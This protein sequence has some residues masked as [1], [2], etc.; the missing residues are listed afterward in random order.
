MDKLR[1]GV[2]STAKI[3][4]KKVMP[5]IVKTANGELTAVASRSLEAANEVADAFHIPHRYGSYLELLESDEIDAVYIPLPND[6]HLEWTLAAAEAGKHVL[7]EKPLALTSVDAQAMVDGCA[8]AGVTFM[9]AFMYRLH[10]SWIKVRELVATGEIGELAA[11]VAGFSF[12]MDDPANIRNRPEHGGGALM[13]I[14]CY[15]IN[16]ARMLFGTEPVAVSASMRRHP[17]FGTDTLTSAV[18]EFPSGQATFTV[19]T[20][21]EPAQFVHVMGSEGRIDVEIPF[22]VPEEH[23]TRIHLIRGG[24]PPLAPG[25]E[26]FRFEP[27]DQYAIEAELFAEAV[28]GGTPVP[29]PPEDGVA[30]MAVI[31]RVKAAAAG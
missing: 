19:S 8:A 1:W 26:T 24:K 13:D 25:I 2:M 30:N 6:L 23:E 21:A 22:N 27:A 7:C 14:G 5:G 17:V 4:V 18:L 29:T 20:L 28:L 3:A 12:F 31:E 16:V 15:P 9:E 11:I 10:P